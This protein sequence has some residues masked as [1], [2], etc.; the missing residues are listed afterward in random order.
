MKK[1]LK[2]EIDHFVILVNDL[3]QSIHWYTTSFGCELIHRDKRLAILDF[4]NI[5]VVLS[6]PGEQRTHVAVIKDDAAS[7]GEITEQND[8][9][10]STFISDPSGNP[11]ELVANPFTIAPKE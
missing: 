8:L 3:E 7:F 6:L 10:F 9:C 11:I 1:D 5:K 4:K 2:S